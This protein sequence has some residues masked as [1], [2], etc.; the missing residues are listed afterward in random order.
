MMMVMTFFLNAECLFSL[1][2]VRVGFAF[3]KIRFALLL[4]FF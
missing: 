3:P 1:D 2:I 4:E